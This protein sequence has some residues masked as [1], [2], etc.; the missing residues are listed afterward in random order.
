M[1]WTPVSEFNASVDNWGATI[2]ATGIGT[3][4]DSHASANTKGT[5]VQLLSAL[6]DDCFYLD[7]IFT[8]SNTNAQVR[9]FLC[10]ILYDPAGG[11]NWQVLIPNLLVFQPTLAYGGYR[12]AFPIFIPAGSTVGVQVQCNTGAT[13]GLRCA[14]RAYGKPSNPELVKYGTKVQALGADTA[15]SLG[16]SVTPGTSA[17]GSY[18]SSLGTLNFDAWWWQCGWSTTDTTL[19]FGT[20]YFIDVAA[21]AT[22]KILCLQ[23]VTL[24]GD[25]GENVYKMALGGHVPIRKISA[26]QDVY[27]RMACTG[28]PDAGISGAA[29]ALGG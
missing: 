18:S 14:V 12:Y 25:S 4:V 3:Q 16:A 26:G 19:V 29:Y 23:D 6:A 15:T 2:T 11:T 5:P 9:S 7:I 28:T 22:N 24:L 21:N 8:R 20:C 10:D 13:T 1:L 17:R 27:I